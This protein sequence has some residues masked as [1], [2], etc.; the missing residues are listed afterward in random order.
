MRKLVVLLVLIVFLGI[1]SGCEVEE[2]TPD[3]GLKAF[4]IE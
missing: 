3:P 4:I 1:T 2:V